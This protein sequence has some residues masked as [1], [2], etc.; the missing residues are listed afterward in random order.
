MTPKACTFYLQ[1]FSDA[2]SDM[3]GY[4]QSSLQSAIVFSAGINRRLYT[5][6]SNNLKDFYADAKGN[7]KKQ[8]HF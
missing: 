4:A 2:L 7:I 6:A 5:Y 1:N 3:R 8:D